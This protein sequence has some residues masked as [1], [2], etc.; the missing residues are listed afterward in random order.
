VTVEFHRLEAG[1]ADTGNLTAEVRASRAQH[2]E[3]RDIERIKTARCCRSTDRETSIVT[4]K[5]AGKD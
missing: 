4:I 2:L 5:L 3:V 1:S